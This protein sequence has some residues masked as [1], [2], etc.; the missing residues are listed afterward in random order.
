MKK[1]IRKNQVERKSSVHRAEE[2]KPM[3]WPGFLLFNGLFGKSIGS[4]DE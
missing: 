2:R 4:L 3:P 1:G